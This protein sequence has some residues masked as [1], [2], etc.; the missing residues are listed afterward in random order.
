MKLAALLFVLG[1]VL[2]VCVTILLYSIRKPEGTLKI[3]R[4]DPERDKYLFVINDDLETLPKK[5][6]ITLNVDP[7]ADLSQK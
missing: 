4:T 5:K 3:D 6:R 1:L 2:G 7:D